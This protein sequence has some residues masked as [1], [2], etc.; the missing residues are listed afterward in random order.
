MR[1]INDLLSCVFEI[2]CAIPHHAQFEAFQPRRIF[3]AFLDPAPPATS[4]SPQFRLGLGPHLRSSPD[5][6][7]ATPELARQGEQN[8]FNFLLGYVITTYSNAYFKHCHTSEKPVL[9]AR[10]GAGQQRRHHRHILGTQRGIPSK[11][12]KIAV[13]PII[14]T[15]PLFGPLRSIICDTSLEEKK[16][17]C[18]S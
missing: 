6:L 13:A 17:V 16:N 10:V 5:S 8:V 4:D 15:N 18:I 7:R 2:S 14:A 9:R 12:R 1:H 11:R 3:S